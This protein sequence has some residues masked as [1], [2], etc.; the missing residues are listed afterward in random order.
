MKYRT[1]WWKN[2][3]EALRSIIFYLTIIGFFALLIGFGILIIFILIKV[4]Y[5]F[6]PVFGLIPSMIIAI[7][8]LCVC[9]YASSLIFD[10]MYYK[11]YVK[12]PVKGNK[13]KTK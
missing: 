2:T 6:T 10:Y 8:I 4:A 11:K 3:K 1:Y 5:L 13:E 9:V 7:V 12:N